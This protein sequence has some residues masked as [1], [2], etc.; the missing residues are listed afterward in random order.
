MQIINTC[1]KIKSIFSNGFDISVWREYAAE[2]SKE[3]PEK[4]E[5]DARNY[6]FEKDILPVISSALQEDKI[7]F[8]N[9]NFQSVI[10]VLNDNLSKLFHGEPDINIILCLGLCNAA[11]WATTLDGKDTVLLGIEKIIELNWGDETN[12]RGLILH[13][14]GHIWHKLNGTLYLHTFTKRRKS[15]EQLWQEG[16]AMVCEQV[17]CDDSDFYHQDKNGWLEWCRENENG[18][19]KEY[20]YRL[21]NG[22]S[23]QDFFGDWCSYNGHSD[24]GYFLGCRFV[25]HLMQSYSLKQIAAMPYRK[26][27]EEFKV[28]AKTETKKNITIERLNP[29]DYPKC[30]N[31]WNME[32]QLLAEKWREEIVSGNRIVF[33]Y[34]I[35][36]E[37]IGE[38]ALVLDT[39]DPDYTIPNKR[40]YVSRMIV[41]K[42]YRNCGIGSELLNFL[43]K[44]AKEMGYSEMA[45]GVDKDNE[46]ALHMYRKFGFTEV[47][48]DGADKDGEYYKLLKRL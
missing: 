43:I 48:F 36:G 20:L 44:K 39:G 23:T 5:T 19:K 40:V 30:S 22:I 6:S 29:E 24:V 25:R 26:I 34:K 13:E 27:N 32:K 16:I 11:G 9:K 38:G 47:L 35:N 41:K 10:K 14:I 15:L 1:D 17:L 42:E 31:I 2:I 45:I 7:D 12:M 46:N 18:I 3:L 33:I 28:F 21:D 8:V 37:F 4:C